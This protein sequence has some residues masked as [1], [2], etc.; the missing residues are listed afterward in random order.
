MH[1][2]GQIL[3]KGLYWLTV[4]GELREQGGV[5]SGHFYT[6]SGFWCGPDDRL[7][8][9][10]EDGRRARVEILGGRLTPAGDAEVRFALT[11]PLA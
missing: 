4:A 1:F 9:L 3:R 7:G 2:R 8:P 5:W 10:L 6:C 11:E